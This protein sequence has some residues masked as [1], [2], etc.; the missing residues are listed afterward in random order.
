[1]NNKKKY[2]PCDQ[3]KLCSRTFA[4]W[5]C[6]LNNADLKSD[7]RNLLQGGQCWPQAEIQDA[8]AIFIAKNGF[9]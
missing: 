2:V 7:L 8:F 1:M 5:L 4:Q 6:R 9:V 3:M